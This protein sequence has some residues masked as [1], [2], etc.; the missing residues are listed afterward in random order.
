MRV[1]KWKGSDTGKM[2]KLGAGENE[3]PNRYTS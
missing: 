1:E 3:G 2:G